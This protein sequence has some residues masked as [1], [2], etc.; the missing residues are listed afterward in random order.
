[1]T[2]WAL[3]LFP[4]WEKRANTVIHWDRFSALGVESSEIQLQTWDH[5]WRKDRPLTWEDLVNPTSPEDI[6]QFFNDHCLSGH[7]HHLWHKA[8]PCYASTFPP[9]IRSIPVV[10][11][12]PDGTTEYETDW[13]KSFK[14]FLPYRSGRFTFSYWVSLWEQ[15]V[16]DYLD[17][18][19][20][21]MTYVELPEIEWNQGPY[22]N[23]VYNEFDI[24][25]SNWDGLERLADFCLF[26]LNGD[27]E[28]YK[29]TPYATCLTKPLPDALLQL[30]HRMQAEYQVFPSK[31]SEISNSYFFHDRVD[32]MLPFYYTEADQPPVWCLPITRKAISQFNQ[33]QAYLATFVN[34]LIHL[35]CEACPILFF[36]FT[37]NDDIEALE[38][39]DPFTVFNLATGDSI[40]GADLLE[41]PDLFW[42]LFF[43]HYFPNDF[44]TEYS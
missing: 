39:P 44:S 9:S 34:D 25:S 17:S 10:T 38:G 42:D 5:L 22:L 35:L 7:T 20:H 15:A 31:Y 4:K 36:L 16:H 29:D 6:A 37:D 41:H 27:L 24:Q 28:C 26:L 30:R 43:H 32:M 19:D 8:K 11:R 12:V 18:L 14:E 40:Q 3:P 33:L 23:H 13:L 1:M 2:L 21:F